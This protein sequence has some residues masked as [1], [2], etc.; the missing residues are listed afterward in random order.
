MQV[1]ESLLMSFSLAQGKLNWSKQ[2]EK[3]G[4]NSVFGL[5]AKICV[6]VL[7]KEIFF[8]GLRVNVEQLCL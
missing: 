7:N 6:Y 4:L 3:N 5:V 1:C 2:Q 8:V